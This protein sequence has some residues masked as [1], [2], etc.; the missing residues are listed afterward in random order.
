MKSTKLSKRTHRPL[1]SKPV[2]PAVF[3]A[4]ANLPR[5][6]LRYKIY[7]AKFFTPASSQQR[8][9]SQPRKIFKSYFPRSKSRPIKILME[10]ERQKVQREKNCQPRKV[11]RERKSTENLFAKK[12][13]EAKK[14][15]TLQSQPRKHLPRTSRK[16]QVT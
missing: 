2:L 16:L 6:V 5:K 13:R 1:F 3:R 9:R 4:K 8:L 11:Q 14:S 15:R 7:E 10:V 12:S